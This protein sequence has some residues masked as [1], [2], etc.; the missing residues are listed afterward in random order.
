MK[1][2]MPLLLALVVAFGA[3]CSFADETLPSGPAAGQAAPEFRLQDQ[4][5]DW[6]TL[7]GEH[8]K[9]LVLYFY[10]K[11]FTPGCTTEVCAYRDDIVA[12]RKA[13]ADVLGV[14]LD[15]VKSHAEFAEKYHVP[16]RLLSDA[17]GKVA[18][19]YG[20]Y[21]KRGPMEY[22]RRETFLIDPQGIVAKRYTDVDPKE[23]SKQVLT[24]L[25]GF[26]Q[27]KH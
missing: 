14:S 19:A 22:A 5:G 25:D 2:L 16:F 10:P 8:G 20:V 4:K 7:K 15:D 9:W 26:K 3:A 21:V 11:D 1:H 27:S 18:K 23:N 13:G 12:L 6:H 17:D 24:D